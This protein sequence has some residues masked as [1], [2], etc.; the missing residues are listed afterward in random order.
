MKNSEGAL[1]TT[2]ES[3]P[4]NEARAKDLNFLD[5]LWMLEM[6]N[7]SFKSILGT[8]IRRI[9]KYFSGRPDLDPVVSQFPKFNN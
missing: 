1:A 7:V 3:L 4:M 6:F 9:P 2:E 8:K 5:R